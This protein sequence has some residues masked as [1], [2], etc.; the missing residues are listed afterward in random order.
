MEGEGKVISCRGSEDE[1]GTQTNH[2]KSGTS[3]L[4]AESIKSRVER[5]SGCVKLETV[6]EIKCRSSLIH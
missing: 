6:T 4:E 3:S 1:K 5:A 2:A